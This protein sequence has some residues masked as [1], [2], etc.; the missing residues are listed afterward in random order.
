MT[1]EAKLGFE[2]AIEL[3]PR[4]C[5]AHGHFAYL[6]FKTEKFDEAIEECATALDINPEYAETLCTWAIS[7]IAK[8]DSLKS[9]AFFSGKLDKSRSN[10]ERNSMYDEISKSEAMIEEAKLQCQKAIGIN[11]KLPDAHN[12][13]GICYLYQTEIEKAEDEFLK[14]LELKPDYVLAHHNLGVLYSK[15]NVI[16]KAAFHLKRIIDISLS[17]NST[18]QMLAQVFQSPQKCHL[19]VE[20]FESLPSLN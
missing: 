2:K 10:P 13:L 12:I 8:C 7:L 16:T 20:A 14:A 19:L 4:Y 3:R 6:Y 18:F 1:N 9:N 5:R 11:P 15:S 17:S